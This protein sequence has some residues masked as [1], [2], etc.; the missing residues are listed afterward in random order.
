MNTPRNFNTELVVFSNHLAY[1]TH[2]KM[3]A[4]LL[5]D[6]QS[7]PDIRNLT[8]EYQRFRS[9]VAHPSHC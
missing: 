1:D 2:K 4:L 8:F 9:P 7:F 6:L 3:F 5:F